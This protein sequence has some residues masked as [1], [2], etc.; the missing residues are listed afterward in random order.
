[1]GELVDAFRLET[2]RLV[3]RD[4]TAADRTPFLKH[5]N[6]PDV[7]E[8]LGGVMDEG[9]MHQAFDRLETY[10]RD[11]GFTF[12]VLE[13]KADGGHLSGEMLGFC[14]LKRANIEGGPIGDLEIGWRLRSDAW[15]KGYAREA[16]RACMD[17]GFTHQPDD[18]MIAMTVEENSPSWGLMLRLGMRRRE[19]LD[20]KA[21]DPASSFA[22]RI[23]VYSIDRKSWEQN[24]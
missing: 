12:W 8:W 1:M 6:T 19:D 2:E 20:F 24:Q 10:Q 22:D 5:T 9:K 7:M 11:H 21:S 16:A 4:W 13:R 15:G 23:I 3:L 14:G 17:W 18:E